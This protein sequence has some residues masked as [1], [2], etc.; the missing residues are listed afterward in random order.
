MKTLKREVRRFVKVFLPKIFNLFVIFSLLFQPVGSAG[1]W[2]VVFAQSTEPEVETAPADVP[3]VEE[4]AST[5]VETEATEEKVVVEEEKQSPV[6]GEEEIKPVTQGEVVTEGGQVGTDSDDST[7]AGDL[8]GAGTGGDDVETSDAGSQISGGD[9]ETDDSEGQAG[10]GIEGDDNNSGNISSGTGESTDNGVLTSQ[11]TTGSVSGDNS[12]I[13]GSTVGGTLGTSSGTDGATNDLGATN[14]KS[15]IETEPVPLPATLVEEPATIEAVIEP[16]DETACLA[17]SITGDSEGHWTID[18]EKNT[19]VTNEPVQLGVR[20]VYPLDKEV[21]IT[22]TCLPKDES[23]RAPLKI[24][25]I[26]ASDINLPDGTIAV[27]E[28]AYDITTEGMDN[29][30]FKYDLTLPKFE[31]VKNADISYI[32]MSV[33]E[34]TNK[35]LEKKDIKQVEDENVDNKIDLI[36]ATNIDH[37]T[38]VFPSVN[39]VCQNDV[40]GVNDITGQKDLTMMCRNTD[41]NTNIFTKWDW[42]DISWSGSNTGDACNLFDT[43][44][45]G[46]VNYAVCVT[47]GGSPAVIQNTTRYSCGD[48]KPDR[49]TSPATLLSVSQNTLCEVNTSNS[50][51]FTGGDAYPSDTQAICSIA[52]ADV[53]GS[54]SAKLIDVCSYPSQQPNSDPSDCII[55][56]QQ[57]TGFLEVVKDLIPSS[58]TGLFNLSIDGSVLATGIGDG[59]T[60]GEQ[61][62]LAS[63]GSGTSHTFGEAGNGS[64][65]LSDYN[66]SAVCRDNNG[67][68]NVVST[69]GTN[70]WTINVV[71][72]KDIVCT[73][74]NTRIN[75]A[76]ITII[77]DAVPNDAQDF[78]FTT[79][80]TGLS[81]FSLDDDADGTLS[82]TKVFSNLSAGTYSVTET[83]PTGWT[84]TSATCSDQSPVNA[85]SLQ[86]GENITCTFTNTKAAT[87][88]VVKSVTNNNGGEK[89]AADFP[90]FVDGNSVTNNVAN[91]F[92][93]GSHTVTETQQTGYSFVSFTGD[94]DSQGQVT[95]N[96]GDAKT[97][98]ITNDDQVGTLIVKKVIVNDNGGNAVVSDFSFKVNGGSNIAFETDAQ[99]DLTVN[100]GTYTVIENV[101]VGYTT[102]YNNCTSV[103]VPNGGSATC[104]ITNDDVA[105]SITLTKVV[106]NNSGGTAGVNAFGLTIGGTAVTS[107]QTLNVS[108]NTSIALNETGLAGYS[109]VSLTGGAK[110]PQVLGGTVTLNEGE[111]VSCTITNDDQA[112]SLTVIKHVVNDNGGTKNAGDF[113]MNVTGTDVSNS[114]FVG[115][116]TGT[117]VTL[118][119]GSYSVDEGSVFGYAKTLGANCSGT[120]A[121]GESKTCTITNDDIQPT[122]TVIKIVNNGDGGNFQPSNFT[123]NITGTSVSPASFQGSAGQLVTLNAGNYNVTE[124]LVSGY[125]PQYSNDCT[126][127]IAVGE[128]K[129]CTITNDDQ[130]PTLTLVKTVINDNSGTKVVGDF[131]LFVNGNPV[132]SSVPV[133]LAAN[134]QYTA[135]ETNQTGYAASSWGGDCAANGTITL[136]PGQNKTCTITND[137]V[138]P[139][140]TVTK[141]VVNDGFGTKVVSNFPLFV[142]NTGVTS[143]VQNGFNAGSYVVSETQQTGY[144]GAISG[145]CA[146]NGSVTLSV[147]DVKNCTITNNDTLG[148]IIVE[149]QTLPDGS[150]QTFEFNP[151]WSVDNFSLADGQQNTSPALPVGTYSVSEIVPSGW[152]QTSAI[153][154]DGSLVGAINLADG[155]TV[156]CVFTNTKRGNIVIVKD[157]QPNRAQDFVFN[158]NFGNGNP[159]TFKLDDDSGTPDANDTYLNSRTFEVLPGRTYAVSENSVVGWQQ[160]SQTCDSGET[161]DS[162]DVAPGE[163]VTCTFVNEKYAKI[164]LVKNTIGGN[165]TFDFD[166]TGADLPTD[167]DLATV[168]G[169]KSQ[170]F[171][172][173]DQD[174]TYTIA[175][176]VPVG[177]DLTSAICNKGETIDSIDLEPGETVTCTFTNSKRPILTLQKTVVKDNGGTANDTDWTLSASGLTSISGVEGN[178]S[179]TNAIVSPGA[180]DLSESDGPSGYTASQYSCVKN[181]SAPVV[182]NSITLAYGDVA[183]CTIT[184]DDIAPKLHLR[185]EISG[186]NA[187]LTDFTLTA[188]G[189]DAN[190]I[191]GTSPVDSDGTLKADTFALSETGPDGYT[192]SAWSCDGGDQDGSSITLG[193][194]E[195]ATC[196]IT[197]TRDTGTIVVHKIIDVDGDIN[198]TDDQSS[199]ENWQFDVDGTSND[200]T[201]P[202]AGVT[203]ADGNVTFSNLYTGEYTIVETKQDGYDLISAYCEN[204]NG[205][206]DLTDSI[207]VVNVTKGSTINCTFYNSPNGTIHGYKWSDEIGDGEVGDGEEKLAGWKIFIDEDGDETFDEG[208][209]FMNTSDGSEHFGWYWF[210]H[211]LPGTYSICE[212]QQ[213]GWNQTFPVNY[214]EDEE[215]TSYCHNVSLPDGNSNGFEETQ[216]ATFGPEYNF[217]NHFNPPVLEISKSNDSSSPENPGNSVIYTITV[218]APKDNTTDVED[219]IVTDL[220][221]AGFTY[222]DGSATAS[223]GSLTHVYASPG[224]WSLGTMTPGQTIT[225]S[226]QATISGN[227]DAGNYEDL[228]FAQGK[229]IVN[230]TETPDVTANDPV[231]SDNFVGTNVEVAVVDTSTVTVPEDNEHKI[232]EKTK[233]KTVLG[234]STTLPSTGVNINTILLALMLLLSGLTLLLLSKRSTWNLIKSLSKSMGKAVKV[235]LFIMFGVL[236]VS[237]SASAAS[238]LSV[239][240]ETPDAVVNSPDFKIGFVTLD[241]LSRDITVKCWKS[242]DV[243]PFQTSALSSGGNS[244]DCQLSASVMPADGDYSFYVTAETTS[245]ASESATSGTVPVK[246]A[247]TV[248]GTPYN[249]DRDNSSCTDNISFTTA[250]DSGKTVK[251]ELYRSLS[252]SFSA[253]ASTK[254]TEQAIGSATDG[255][256]SVAAPGCDD[257]YF[258]A[259]RAVDIY[260]FASAFVGDVDRNVNEETITHTKTSVVGGTT[261]STG[262]IPVTGGGESAGVVEGAATSG[263][264]I[265]QPSAEQQGEVLGEAT[266]ESVEGA[267]GPWNWIK[268]HPWWS[269]LWLGIIFLIAYFVRRMYFGNY[270]ENN[271]QR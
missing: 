217:G 23:K 83:V 134:T 267:S 62:V 119:A 249:Y 221:P 268:N 8:N 231:E 162:I 179:V 1:I 54:T 104:T 67:T 46:D 123:I 75:N 185:K 197:N 131:P 168:N 196:T 136:L 166:A 271:P 55:A 6:Q 73:I 27:S 49:C 94:C 205:E 107:G 206:F 191:S 38:I 18:E 50:D 51:P 93:L 84:Q 7:N 171:S 66:T 189:T 64:T 264:E 144:T 91:V 187:T 45:D 172:N 24:E 180:Y 209:T 129:T 21:T 138:Q 208:E 261:S 126:G 170:T 202:A 238:N 14:E 175:E 253:D 116:E 65:N 241:I 150:T 181:N 227:Q 232:V 263:E 76:S 141:V 216:N 245:G 244:G 248:P 169:T 251:V 154:S 25:R 26:K 230:D 183:T 200:T 152:D 246:L 95:L 89:T 240:I 159:I 114:T 186:G 247:M 212:V 10:D 15:T 255:S 266:S 60:T 256:F 106:T 198:T 199:G 128:T 98:T 207:D 57:Q 80:G 153:C 167:I 233:K 3:V 182:G 265:T 140:L 130:A 225:L 115:S 87:L 254:V 219:V 19:A 165:G 103:N 4:P 164:K 63:G 257:N 213:T 99:N 78:D 101:A 204:E 158:N 30:S 9:G 32:E 40:N 112:A 215:T 37:F 242:G 184:N 61:V 252:T 220:P 262:A 68:G 229:S 59:G 243:S 124:T 214:D 72:D 192:A 163:T 223:Q 44:N 28:Y 92:A 22:F 178:V 259:I 34:V 161:I 36:E 151:S 193:I 5:E 121:L 222:V 16:V 31:G 17:A 96:A 77:K 173:L 111:N 239:Q 100:A 127:S 211:L 118:D 195:K 269:L 203:G 42:D 48:D 201:D 258:Y 69:T 132:T 82:N 90:L 156:T 149:K 71:K 174:N 56:T 234:T 79:T 270:N 137:D 117:V 29:G 11:Q 145:D 194:N 139:K 52:L 2:N 260:G 12:D 109:F 108:A 53:G 146:A 218:T 86:A 226:Y 13:D 113:T 110:C 237:H 88:K 235:S 188:D 135:S 147:G 20:Y 157:A 125:V 39:V 35:E 85:I 190:D 122:L 250:S 43:N 102:T 224:E 228:A 155:E 41:V 58:D 236:L 176:N 143:G 148:K 47:I 133:V 97:C 120:I 33:D 160:E 74:T 70:P 81:S 142:D 177:W 210:E 105:P